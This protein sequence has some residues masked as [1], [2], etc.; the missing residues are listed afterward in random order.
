MF[1][2]LETL[3]SYEW[4]VF[5]EAHLWYVLVED[6]QPWMNFLLRMTLAEVNNSLCS[7]KNGKW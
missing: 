2:S 6:G 7:S 5:Y 4:S 3:S 1:Y